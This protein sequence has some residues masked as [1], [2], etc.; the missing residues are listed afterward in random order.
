MAIDPNPFEALQQIAAGACLPR[1]L[2][3]V[4][5][6]GVADALD[7]GPQTTT[8]LATAVGAHPDALHR[9]LRLLSANGVFELRGHQVQHTL[10]SRLLRADHP[11]SMKS[12]ALMFGLPI[13]WS[14]FLDFRHT[15]QTG[16]PASSKTLPG[17]YWSYFER[18]PTAARIF[19][20]AMSAKAQGQVAAIMA[21]YDFSQF[22]AIAD[23]GGGRGHLLSAVLNAT[24][25]ATGVLFDLPHVIRE[26][27]AVATD[28]L[29]LQAG[30]FFLDALP[31]CDLYLLMEVIH[32]WGDQEAT[33]IL[34]AIR[35][36]APDGATLLLLESVVPE[37]P[38][39]SFT[40]TL[41]IVMLALLGG[42]QRSRAEYDA[43]L[44]ESGF[45]IGRET[46]TRGGIS[47]LEATVS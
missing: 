10:E 29:I 1:C 18:D 19:N 41:D 26:A 3:V 42:K 17:G 14:S 5:E 4:A 31:G 13:N 33:L 38:G 45:S 23:I 24:P 39:P 37:E 6:L 40:K 12:F 46:P 21:A 35:R 43:L 30:D 7:E 8:E 34:R 2:H 47:I 20:A 9:I 11:Q 15:A 22:K 32:D 44:S 27:S 28:R 25:S 36:A 16:Q